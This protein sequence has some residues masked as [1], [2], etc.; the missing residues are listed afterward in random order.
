MC[1]TA[2]FS[3]SR[4]LHHVGEL[5]VDEA[6]W[7]LVEVLNVFADQDIAGPEEDRYHGHV[8]HKHRLCIMH[9]LHAHL[10][11]TGAL[12]FD[13]KSVIRLAGPSGVVVATA[14]LEDVEERVCI[15]V[16]GAPLCKAYIVEPV[17]PVIHVDA[18]L[19]RTCLLYTSDAAD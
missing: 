5:Q 6:H 3:G 14:R 11:I 8:R 7:G 19:F 10:L 18:A 2:V 16:V 1:W 13:D 17:V 15:H 12:L 9:G 4:T